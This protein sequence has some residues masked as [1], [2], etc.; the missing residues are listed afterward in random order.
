MEHQNQLEVSHKILDVGTAAGFEEM[1][2]DVLKNEGSQIQSHAER[3]CWDEVSQK[4]ALGMS[5][6]QWEAWPRI[7]R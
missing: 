2:V 3:R 1:P 6:L 4:E 5:V 7:Q